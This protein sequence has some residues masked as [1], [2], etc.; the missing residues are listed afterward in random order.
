[1]VA[2]MRF[3]RIEN[4]P[5]MMLAYKGVVNLDGIQQFRIR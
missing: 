5:F 1:M 3:R 4:P 2:E